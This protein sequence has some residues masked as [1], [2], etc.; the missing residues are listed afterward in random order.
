MCNVGF[1]CCC[2]RN[3]IAPTMCD[4]RRYL[5]LTGRW[6]GTARSTHIMSCCFCCRSS[7]QIFIVYRYCPLCRS[8]VFSA[9][10]ATSSRVATPLATTAT[11]GLRCS[12]LMHSLPSRRPRPRLYALR[13]SNAWVPQTCAFCR[14]EQYLHLGVA[15]EILCWLWG[16]GALL[17]AFFLT[18]V[19]ARHLF[20]P[21]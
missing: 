7:D 11:S 12:L 4:P 13:S 9:V 18:S 8:I 17:Q 20:V 1:L 6:H 10:L 3:K 21:F 2:E 16:A 14:T 5:T 15:F 19:Y